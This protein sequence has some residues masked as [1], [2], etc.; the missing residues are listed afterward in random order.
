MQALH[1]HSQ[2]QSLGANCCL[3]AEISAHI[4]FC[5]GEK[6]SQRNR[7]SYIVREKCSYNFKRDCSTSYIIFSTEKLRNFIGALK[8][9]KCQDVSDFMQIGS[10]KQEKESDRFLKSFT[11]N[12]PGTGN[13]VEGP[14]GSFGLENQLS[15]NA[16]AFHQWP[17]CLNPRIIRDERSVCSSFDIN[18]QDTLSRCAH[19]KTSDTRS[20]TSDG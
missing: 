13:S 18:Q 10:G 19:T 11:K 15:L 17:L 14:G 20:L 12:L 5:E 16:S 3:I 9:Y 6:I 4:H 7:F 2:A 8:K 1:D